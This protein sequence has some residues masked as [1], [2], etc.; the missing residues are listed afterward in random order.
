M[1]EPLQLGLQACLLGCMLGRML[2]AVDQAPV[3]VLALC[4]Q[5]VPDALQLP[6]QLGMGL[7]CCVIT[8]LMTRD[9]GLA[10]KMA[11]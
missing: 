8:W 10:A 2:P 3:K 4:P 5:L 9:N 1:E 6:V 11:S 7:C